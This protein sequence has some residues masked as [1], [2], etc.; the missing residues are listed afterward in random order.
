LVSR[1]PEIPVL[2]TERLRLRSWSELDVDALQSTYAKSEVTQ[3]FPMPRTEPVTLGEIQAQWHRYGFGSWVVADRKTDQFL[4]AITLAHPGH[5]PTP[6]M[7]WVM[8]PRFW[9]RGYATEAAQAV[10]DY[11]FVALEFLEIMGVCMVLNKRSERVMQK[12][13][14]K[15][16]SFL[17]TLGRDP[18]ILTYLLTQE[19]WSIQARRSQ[20]PVR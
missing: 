15:R 19:Q 20:T 3:F 4:G 7:Y 5:W 8:N 10:V 6:E 2:L 17:A 11:A 14:M 12:L 9:G 16:T 18:L 1:I 13:G